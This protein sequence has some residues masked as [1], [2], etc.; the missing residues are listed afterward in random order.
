VVAVTNSGKDDSMPFFRDEAGMR[1]WLREPAREYVN[2]EVVRL[3]SEDGRVHPRLTEELKLAAQVDTDDIAA[4]DLRD[5]QQPAKFHE[6]IAH[7][8]QLAADKGLQAQE[9]K[10]IADLLAGRAPQR[11]RSTTTRVRSRD[12]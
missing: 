5:E 9:A 6:I 3:F 1:E 4:S 2:P 12:L 11:S 8:S 7:V 10:W